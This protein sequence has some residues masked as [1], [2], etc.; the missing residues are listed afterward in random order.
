MD[1]NNL[2]RNFYKRRKSG[3]GLNPHAK[4]KLAYLEIQEQLDLNADPSFVPK[5]WEIH[6]DL[7]LFPAHSFKSVLIDEFLSRVHH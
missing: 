7:V 2:T 1:I 3:C 5:H 4:L 6:Q